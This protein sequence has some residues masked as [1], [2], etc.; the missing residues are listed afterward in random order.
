Q[1]VTRR[2]TRNYQFF[3]V[4]A[5]RISAESWVTR[6]R[7]LRSAFGLDRMI[8][9]VALVRLCSFAIVSRPANL[10]SIDVLL[11]PVDGLHLPPCLTD[12]ASFDNVDHNQK[13]LMVVIAQC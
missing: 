7:D 12:G 5:R 3:G 9:P 10:D 13:E 4:I 11:Y 6:T 8:A 1:H 2:E